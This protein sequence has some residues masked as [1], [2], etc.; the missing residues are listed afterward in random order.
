MIGQE[1]ILKDENL[2]EHLI[3]IGLLFG[4]LG[5]LINNIL[6][7]DFVKKIIQLNIFN[8]VPFGEDQPESIK[9]LAY[10]KE[11]SEKGQKNFGDEDVNELRAD[12]TRL[13]IGPG[14]VLAPLWESVH[15]TEDRL[16][17]QEN[18]LKVRKWYRSFNL[19]S[20]KIYHEP[21]DHIGLE[22]VFIAHLAGMA[23]QAVESQD[24]QSLRKYLTAIHQFLREHPLQWAPLWSDLVLKH[25][26]TSFYKGLALLTVGSLKALDSFVDYSKPTETT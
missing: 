8:E 17:F 23:L 3:G 14:K 18:T 20:E 5:K 26:Q 25:A 21:E 13:F 2:A 22:L 9:G 16:V 6:E 12:Y 19:E 15:F 10:L 1:Q 7:P 24:D 4:T 11:W